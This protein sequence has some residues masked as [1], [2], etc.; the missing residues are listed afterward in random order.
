MQKKKHAIVQIYPVDLAY[1]LL[2]Y[3]LHIMANERYI[4]ANN[5]AIGEGLGRGEQIAGLE[6]GTKKRD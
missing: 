3:C 2:P 6:G 1:Q 4:M 5:L